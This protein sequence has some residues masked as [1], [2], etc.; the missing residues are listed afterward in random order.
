[1][2]VDFCRFFL[3]MDREILEN[4]RFSVLKNRQKID[5]KKRVSVIYRFTTLIAAKCTG[6]LGDDKFRVP[7]KSKGSHGMGAG[8]VRTAA[9]VRAPSSYAR[10][11]R[12]IN[13]I[14]VWFCGFGVG[15]G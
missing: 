7:E 4:S 13:P 1:M 8:G 3:Q 5:R 11:A 12:P 10:L 15:S 14:G 2:S 6:W 9:G